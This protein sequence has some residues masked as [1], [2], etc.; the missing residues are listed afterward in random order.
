MLQKPPNILDNVQIILFCS[1]FFDLCCTQKNMAPSAVT[2]LIQNV[3]EMF[4]H[5]KHVKG[6]LKARNDI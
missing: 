1:H 5:N 4:R 6:E 3:M 2:A